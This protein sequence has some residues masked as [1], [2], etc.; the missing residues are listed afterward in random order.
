MIYFPTGLK[1][2]DISPNFKHRDE[3]DNLS[4]RMISI[5][6]NMRFTR[7]LLYRELSNYLSP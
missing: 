4:Y 6:E 2:N 3:T 1:D 5:L 7:N